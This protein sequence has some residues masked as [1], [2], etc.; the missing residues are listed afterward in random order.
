MLLKLALLVV[1]VLNTQ[2]LKA[3]LKEKRPAKR[4]KPNSQKREVKGMELLP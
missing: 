2:K 1:L 4:P 3:L